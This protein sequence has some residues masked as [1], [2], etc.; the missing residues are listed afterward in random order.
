M[1]TYV[2]PAEIQRIA[3]YLAK[4]RMR[5]NQ[6]AGTTDYYASYAQTPD[7]GEL[8]GMAGE[9]A[10]CSLNGSWPD[11]TIGVRR[12]GYDTIVQGWR[13]DVKTT[14]NPYG[15]LLLNPKKVHGDIDV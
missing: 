12:G 8:E 1:L 3:R 5:A 10:F 14:A 15:Q 9:L 2:L 7:E 13:V 6:N 4:G 11:M